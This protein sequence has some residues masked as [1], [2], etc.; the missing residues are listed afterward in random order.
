MFEGPIQDLIDELAKLPGLGPKGAQRIAFH[1]L[2]VER[3]EIGRLT[4][5]LERVR[6]DMIFCEVCGNVAAAVRCRI[7]LDPRRDISKICVVE[8]TRDIHAIERTKE[9]SGRYHILGGALNPLRGVG[10]N[11]LRIRELLQR[12]AAVEDGVS[13]DEIIIATDPNNEGEATATYLVRLLRDFPGLTVTRP[14]SGL[15]MGSD[16]EFADEVTLGRALSGRTSLMT[17]APVTRTPVSR[18]PAAREPAAR[19]P[20]TQ[21]SVAGAPV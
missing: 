21:A 7:C 12:L 8:E 2:G 13:V 17:R 15:P 4:A 9:F 10:P 19:E 16:L 11:E 3:T 1:L 5:A 20:V 18:E 14:A 6:D